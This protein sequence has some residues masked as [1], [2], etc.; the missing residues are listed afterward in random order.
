MPTAMPGM[1]EKNIGQYPDNVK[2]TLKNKHYIVFFTTSEIILTMPISKK[3]SEENDLKPL[4]EVVNLKKMDAWILRIKLENSNFSS[5]EGRNKFQCK[6]NYFKGNNKSKWI[7]DVPI[8]EEIIYKNIYKNIDLTF[9]MNNNKL[10]YDFILNKGSNVKDIKISFNGVDKLELMDNSNLRLKMHDNSLEITSPLT[11]QN[12]NHIIRSINSSLIIEDNIISFN[13][14]EYDNNY[15]LIIDPSFIYGSYIGGSD[16]DE[17]K[18]IAIDSKGL[19]YICGNTQSFDF[20]ITECGY[21][22]NFAGQLDAFFVKLNP[23]INGSGALLYSS[24]I[25][26]ASYDVSNAL[27]TSNNRFAYIYGTTYSSDFPVTPNAYQSTFQGGQSDSFLVEIDTLACKEASF[28]Y[29]SFLGGSGDDLGFGISIDNENNIYMCGTTE[30]LNFPTTP[31]G[32]SP[33]KDTTDFDGFILKLNL[34]LAPTEQLQYGSF[35]GGNLY[36]EMISIAANNNQTAYLT[37]RTNSPLYFPRTLTAYQYY[38]PGGDYCTFIIVI[39]TLKSGSDSLYYGSYLGGNGEDEGYSISIDDEY[40]YLTG[41]TSSTNFPVTF[42]GYQLNLNGQTNA[43]LTK[44]D[45]TS[46]GDLCLIYSSYLGGNGIVRGTG[47]A[48]DNSEKVFITGY[49]GSTSGFPI[50]TTAFQKTFQGGLYDAFL[51][52][53]DTLLSGNE[54]LLYGS[55][56]GGEDYDYGIGL[57]IDIFNNVY[58]SGFT[59]STNFPVTLNS[60]QPI[61]QGKGDAYLIKINPSLTD[62][63]LEVSTCPCILKNCDKGIISI[64]ITNNG[65]DLANTLSIETL[66]PLD[67]KVISVKYSKGRLSKIGNKIIWDI[68]VLKPNESE[69]LIIVVKPRKYVCNNTLIFDTTVKSNSIILNPSTASTKSAF[70]ITDQC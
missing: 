6:T 7:L 58:I 59:A 33:D 69:I 26:G 23:N 61:Y 43:F 56:L 11:Y 41:D 55:Y 39:D 54:G 46:S 20:P 32:Y 3:N 15:P 65:P 27:T 19:V 66:I 31:S 48:T 38:Y 36:D 14:N 21:Q 53:I 42:T 45:T 18:A 16:F 50:T 68:N 62:L 13:V 60:Y 52:R 24:Y 17:G 8:Y 63:A 49:V 30:S 10:E 67:L 57:A 64:K 29:G 47:I 4:N 1:I 51:I 28:L 37:G 35:L 2:F 5:L 34:S 25:G 44:L 70:Y 12:I 22:P 9:Y 40:A